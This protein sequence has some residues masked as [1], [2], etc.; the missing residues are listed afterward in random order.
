MPFYD[1]WSI[2]R[3]VNYDDNPFLPKVTRAQAWARPVGGTTRPFDIK[4]L[5]FER[6]RGDC[7]PLGWTAD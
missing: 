3:P 1:E 7:I 2:V 6:T 4:I 5:N